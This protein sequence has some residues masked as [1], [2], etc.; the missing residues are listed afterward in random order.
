MKARGLAGFALGDV[1]QGMGLPAMERGGEGRNHS[2]Q[3]GA[4]HVQ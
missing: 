3:G 1:G 2:H 4:A